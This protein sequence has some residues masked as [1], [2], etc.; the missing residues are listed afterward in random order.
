MILNPPFESCHARVGDVPP[1]TSA[2]LDANEQ[3]V[4]SATDVDEQNVPLFT[5]HVKADASPYPVTFA[6]TVPGDIR[7]DADSRQ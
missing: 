6:V 2:S 5:R 1:L 7:R 4:P 3:R